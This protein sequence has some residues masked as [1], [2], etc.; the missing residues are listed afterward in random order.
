[1]ATSVKGRI[2]KVGNSQGIRI[3]KLLLEQSGISENVEIEVRDNQ[4]V[5]TAA[6][7]AR[8]GW[9]EAFARVSSNEDEDILL[10]DII[11]TTWDEEEW[12]W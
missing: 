10:D 5:I 3:P 2:I 4:I 8:T 11:A 9:A 6:S 12:E 1:M 7:R